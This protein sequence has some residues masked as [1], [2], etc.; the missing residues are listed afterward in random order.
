LKNFPTVMSNFCFIISSIGG[1]KILS[2]LLSVNLDPNIAYFVYQRMPSDD[3]MKALVQCI[4]EDIQRDI[5]YLTEDSEIVPGCIY[6]FSFDHQYRFEDDWIRVLPIAA[7][8]NLSATHLDSI[9]ISAGNSNHRSSV[10]VLSGIFIDRDGIGGIKYLK[11][12]GSKIY[13][14]L[15]KDTPVFEMI[16]DLTEQNL[17]DDL[18]SPHSVLSHL[19]FGPHVAPG[20]H[21][22]KILIVDDEEEIRN[23]IGDILSLENVFC[24]LATDGLDAISKIQRNKYSGI[25][26][27]MKM[28]ELNGVKTLAALQT[29]EPNLPILIITGFDD[30]Q[31][32]DAAKSENVVG[33]L[34]KP[35]TGEDIKKYL[36][37]LFSP[38]Q[39]IPS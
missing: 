34:I 36:P 6:F 8:D 16:N 2:P 27:D 39:K 33:V 30:K 11:D 23:V 19:E 12:S 37:R 18:Y 4:G 1:P 9:L 21:A 22:E 15:E 32:H 5:I 24:D 29:M 25:I 10:V 3:F 31:T 28:P 38:T 14:T 26:L 17:I 20:T 13:G 35:F 7:D